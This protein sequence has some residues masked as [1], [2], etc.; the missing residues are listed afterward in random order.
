MIFPAALKIAGSMI[1]S[2]AFMA[3]NPRW[4]L[5]RSMRLAAKSGL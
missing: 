5:S 1:A 3:A 4:Y 2:N